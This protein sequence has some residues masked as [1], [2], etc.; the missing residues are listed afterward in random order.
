MPR[1]DSNL[2]FLQDTIQAGSPEL[3]SLHL[4][5]LVGRGSFGRVYKGKLLCPSQLTLSGITR[6]SCWKNPTCKSWAASVGPQIHAKRC[7]AKM[8]MHAAEAIWQPSHINFESLIC[9]LK[10]E[11]SVCS[12]VAGLHSGREGAES[13]GQPVCPRQRTA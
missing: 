4:E 3:R 1:R 6:V 9:I 10:I 13:R 5:K 2:D 7:A 11:T 12:Q 8:M